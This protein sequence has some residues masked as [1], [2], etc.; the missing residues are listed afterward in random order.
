[1]FAVKSLAEA[2]MKGS[3]FWTCGLV[4]LAG[5]YAV[6]Q[7]LEQTPPGSKAASA[8]VTPDTGARQRAINAAPQ[9]R[10]AMREEVN[11]GLV[12]IIAEGMD[13][14][15]L[16]KATDLSASLDGIEDH[17]RILPVAGKGA[18]QDVTDIV[19]AR[20]IDIGIIHSDVLAALKHDPPF[21]GVENFLQYITRLYDEEV[22]VLA[23]KDIQSVED[24]ASKKVN[25]GIRGSGTYMT[26]NAIFDGLGITVDT[27]SFSQAVALE[28][29]RR[30]E[31]SA[32]VYVAGKP[33]RLFQDIRPDEHLHFLSITATNDLRESYKPATLRA[34]DYPELIEKDGP[35]AT[36]AV[37]SVL[38]VYNWP[39]GSERHRRVARFVQ[40]FFDRL[41]DMQ[42]PPH[43]PK[44][45]DIDLA[46]SVPGW[47]RFAPAE[48]WIRRAELGNDERH[49]TAGLHETVTQGKTAVLSAQERDV[50]FT[51]FVD[52]QKRQTQTV[53]NAGLLDPPQLDLL[54]T[55]FVDYQ[56]RQTHTVKN[57]GLLDPRQLDVLFT[58]F[59]DYQ[60][61]QTHTVKNAGLPDPRQRDTLFTEFV[62]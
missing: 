36:V 58:E 61:R 11:S 28:K 9:I 39:A 4:L 42:A 13:G 60:K 51:E 15:D 16:A 2:A 43:H 49:R 24:L 18:F 34:E 22:H 35:V 46:A 7:A 21:P 6:A 55:E 17:L 50:V 41:H 37:G 5:Q 52:Y 26:A 38:A 12:G 1:V 48:Q 56:K 40:A 33:A 57:A 59:V 3:I 10:R 53:K 19:F 31:I 45:R 14:T 8:A 62:N 27:T 32:L 47:T 29:L 54:F 44:W 23:D 20:G 25:F 30:G